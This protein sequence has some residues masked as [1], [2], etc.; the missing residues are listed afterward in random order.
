MPLK[1]PSGNPMDP[2]LLGRAE[3]EEVLYEAEMPVLYT[4]RNAFG[5]LLLAYVADDAADAIWLVLAPC[6]P[7]AIGDLKQG[8]LAVREALTASWLWLA[9]KVPEGTIKKVWA[10][11]PDDLPSEH[12]PA[13][14]TPLLPEHEPVIDYASCRRCDC[15]RRDSFKRGRLRG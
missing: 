9:L 12:L 4:T 1:E 8:R 10:I 14:G 13:P 5:Q 2:A 15:S 7:R 11:T 3:I 6:A